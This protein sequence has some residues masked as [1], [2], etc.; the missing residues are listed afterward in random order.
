M[1]GP[2]PT[3]CLFV[4]RTSLWSAPA[5]SVEEGE[6]MRFLVLNLYH[7][8]S[9]VAF[10]PVKVIDKARRAFPEAEFLPGDQ[11]AAEVERAEG[12]LADKLRSDP[13]GPASK[14]IAS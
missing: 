4:P 1:N 5:C 11:A 8:P 12:F 2:I 14:V 7:H 13:N 9:R 6:T 10:D 3:S